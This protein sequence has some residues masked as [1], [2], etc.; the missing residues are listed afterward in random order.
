MLVWPR[1]L[2]SGCKDRH[3]PRLNPGAAA[4]PWSRPTPWCSDV[5]DTRCLLPPNLTVPNEVTSIKE[6]VISREP[7]ANVIKPAFMPSFSDCR[8]AELLRNAAQG[9]TDPAIPTAMSRS[10]QNSLLV[11]F[12]QKEVKLSQEGS[13]HHPLHPERSFPGSCWFGLER[14]GW[15]APR[16]A[17]LRAARQ[18]PAQLRRCVQPRVQRLLRPRLPL[19]PVSPRERQT[20]RSRDAPRA[21]S[22]VSVKDG[23]E[24][25]VVSG[26]S[27]GTGPG[28]VSALLSENRLGTAVTLS[29]FIKINRGGL[30]PQRPSRSF[31]PA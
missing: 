16:S 12:S 19:P 25:L 26:L 10:S 3:S 28:G 18:P 30:C 11:S 22:F 2:R 9:G 24:S 15:A 31:S 7:F 5:R 29:I 13:D 21:A 4:R 1:T 23:L 20:G 8:R 17:G 14:R 27:E 6:A